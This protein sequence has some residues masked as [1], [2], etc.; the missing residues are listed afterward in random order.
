MQVSKVA[1]L[2]SLRA[3]AAKPARKLK[4]L[5]GAGVRMGTAVGG[6]LPD[7]LSPIEAALLV[8]Q[9]DAITPENLL[10][11]ELVQPEEGRFT[12]A[13]GDAFV[14][15]AEQHRLAATGHCLVWHQQFPGWMFRDGV[16]PASAEL[17]M[18]RLQTHI[19]TVVGRYVGRLQG[20]D[21]VNEAIAE[22]GDY[23]R[24]TPFIEI[25]GEACLAQAFRFAHDADPR[26]ELY[27]NDF[28]IE[29]PDKLARTL[30]FLGRLLDQGVPVHGVGI[31]GHWQLDQVPFDDIEVAIES[32]AALGLKVMV[33]ELDIDVVDRPDCGADVSLHHAYRLEEDVYRR[34][35]PDAVLARQAEQYAE[36]FRRLDRQRE[37]LSRVSFWGLHD[38]KSWLNTW[39][40]MRTNHPLL[41]D[42]ACQ[43]KIA[44]EAIANMLEKRRPS[45]AH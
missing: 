1:Q 40:G 37:R 36:L 32:F 29:Q 33:T 9:F 12:F 6:V 28:N 42:R 17:L 15:F 27:Y 43:P 44:Y 22:P 39:P 18:R 30:R 14:A 10:K 2:Q 45:V 19:E 31:E 26:A 5:L 38:G 8:E 3:V 35:C 4:G 21:V 23:L 7:A 13:G 34:G 20:W 41:F 16:G 25:A 24:P 11:P